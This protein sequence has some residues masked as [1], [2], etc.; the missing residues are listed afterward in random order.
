MYDE[1]Y[2]K[3]LNPQAGDLKANLLAELRGYFNL[4]ARDEDLYETC[5]NAGASIFQQ[6]RERKI[7][8]KDKA[9]VTKFYVETPLYCYEL[10]GI[11]IDAPKYRQDQLKDFAELLKGNQK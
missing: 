10:L 11:E 8:P 4:A 3:A 5:R 9:A 6:W 1:H 7:D 2:L